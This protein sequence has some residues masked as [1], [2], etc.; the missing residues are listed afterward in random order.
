MDSGGLY[1]D[2]DIPPAVVATQELEARLDAAYSRIA[3]LEQKAALVGKECVTL[4]K[5]N[6]VLR[7]NISSLYK[8][9]KRE[10]ER[11]ETE[12]IK[13]R[14]QVQSWQGGGRRGG[15]GKEAHG[16][17]TSGCERGEGGRE[18]GWQKDPMGEEGVGRDERKR[19]TRVWR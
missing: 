12:V 11:K 10:L 3:T 4:R 1:E 16:D 6:D 15:E 18:G 9:A 17:D 5:E 8:T 19:G 13:L 14:E 2:L 7:V